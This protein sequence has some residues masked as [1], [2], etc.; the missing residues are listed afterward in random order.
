MDPFKLIGK[1]LVATFVISSLLFVF[2]VQV[3][4]YLVNR[5][6]EKVGEAFGYL[7]RG[8]IDAIADIFR[9]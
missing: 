8:V 1:L 5:R 9:R 3:V 4:W 6:P 7:G 2:I